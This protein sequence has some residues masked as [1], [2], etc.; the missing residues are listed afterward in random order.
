MTCWPTSSWG[1]PLFSLFFRYSSS[2]FSVPEASELLLLRS[3]PPFEHH[4][5]PLSRLVL[6]RTIR[7]PAALSQHWLSLLLRTPSNCSFIV[8]HAVI[9]VVKR[10]AGHHPSTPVS[11]SHGRSVHHGVPRLLP[12]LV[13]GLARRYAQVLKTQR[14]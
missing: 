4:T 3:A 1:F 9:R 12:R 5:K 11:I 8:V 6:P 2:S 7:Q 14:L 10:R 13:L